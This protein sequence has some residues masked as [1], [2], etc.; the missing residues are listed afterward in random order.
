MTATVSVTYS[1]A[2]TGYNDLRLLESLTRAAG[3]L[4]NDVTG[5][6]VTRLAS[7]FTAGDTSAVVESTY[8]FPEAGTIWLG[9]VGFTY[10][11][12]TDGSFDGL[13][14]I[15]TVNL[16]SFDIG[17]EVVNDVSALTPEDTEDPDVWVPQLDRAFRDTIPMLATGATALAATRA[18]WGLPIYAGDPQTRG[19]FEVACY[20]PRDRRQTLIQFL[21]AV[22]SD[23]ETAV[24]VTQSTGTPQRITG[25]A[26]T[27][28]A[29]MVGR[30]VYLAS[31]GADTSTDGYYEIREYISDTAVNLNHIAAARYG[32]KSASWSANNTSTAYLLGWSLE[33][34]PQIPCS[35]NV[36]IWEFGGTP[37]PGNYMQPATNWLLYTSG[38]GGP[39]VAGDTLTGLTSGFTATIA[40]V[41]TN[42]GTTGAV[43]LQDLAGTPINGEVI[44]GGATPWAGLANGTVGDLLVRYD[45]ESGGGFAVGDTVNGASG[46]AISTVRGLQDNGTDGYLVTEYDLEASNLA[47]ATSSYYV[48]N[49]DLEVSATVRGQAFGDSQTLERPSSQAAWGYI[50]ADEATDG[51]TR[52]PLYLA[53]GSVDAELQACLDYMVA[54]GVWARVLIGGWVE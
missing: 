8:G 40:R 51:S 42:S 28:S 45:G 17:T 47:G 44:S 12:T 35:V 5:R 18:L 26:S 3:E 37:T 7:A 15:L 34:D 29:A 21:R 6:I 9:G 46:G 52:R 54:A 23:R 13:A 48:D 4:F 14:S 1:G 38:L 39:L 49:E 19:G 20:A 36:R 31:Q 50:T 27:F 32:L 16:E 10:T 22:L 43:Q 33:E 30:W 2:I 41:V 25:P 53:G 24:T 11:S